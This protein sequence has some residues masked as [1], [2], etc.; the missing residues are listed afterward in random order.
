MLL[1]THSTL[2]LEDHRGLGSV[3]VKHF[4]DAYDYFNQSLFQNRLPACVIIVARKRGAYGYF[5]NG[6]WQ[7]NGKPKH[8]IALNPDWLGS[9]PHGEVLSTL[10]HE[11][12]HLWQH[13]FGK[14]TKVHHN[15]QWANK[16]KALGL[17]PSSTGKP[18]G[19]ELGMRVSHYIVE[20]G[21]FATSNANLLNTGFELPVQ[22]RTGFGIGVAPKAPKYRTTVRCPECRMSALTKEG[23][24]MLCAEHKLVMLTEEEIAN[25]QAGI[26]GHQTWTTE[27]GETLFGPTAILTKIQELLAKGENLSD[28]EK[29][30]ETA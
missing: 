22:T 7:K 5:W 13:E 10:V 9:R 8:E 27:D 15:R 6:Q 14:V 26:D 19:K 25:G 4:E 18:G 29:D 1:L 12:V 17:H 3:L 24:K 11:M 28:I 23:N 2:A 30:D 21:P 16:M 20:G